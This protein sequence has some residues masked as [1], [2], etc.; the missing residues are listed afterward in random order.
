ME[1]VDK[2]HEL[3]PEPEVSNFSVVVSQTAF[4]FPQLKKKCYC[5]NHSVS[6]EKLTLWEEVRVPA[7]S[8]SVGDR[9]PA[10]PPCGILPLCQLQHPGTGVVGCRG[11]TLLSLRE[12]LQGTVADH[13][14]PHSI[15]AVHHLKSSRKLPLVPHNRLTCAPLIREETHNLWSKADVISLSHQVHSKIFS[16]L[17]PKESKQKQFSM[18]G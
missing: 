4:F 15:S 14:P 11:W 13:C 10:S 3:A 18:R 2:T 5:Q 8:K 17:P 9:M 6:Q 7:I 1:K 16:P 12:A